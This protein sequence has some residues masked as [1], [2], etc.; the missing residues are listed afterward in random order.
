ML[1]SVAV[2]VVSPNAA[3]MDDA[4]P[5]PPTG[6]LGV[7]SDMSV[8]QRLDRR[9]GFTLI[10]LLVVIAIIAVLIALL[11][12][13]VQQ[14]REAARRVQ[15]KNNLKQIG[16]ALHNY[17]DANKVFPPGGCIQA[18]TTFAGNNGSWSIHGRILPYLEFTNAL[19]RVNLTVAWDNVINTSTGV[20]LLKV[21]T[22]VC[23]SELNSLFR[24]NG[25][26]PYT[27]PHTYGFNM[28]SWLIWDPATGQ[29]SDGI[30]W[31]NSSTNPA[32]IR[33]GLSSTLGAAEVKAFTSQSPR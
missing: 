26:A 30:F 33:D 5:L 28:G 13:A 24:T 18:G 1:R 15:C 29:G 27:Q 7:R 20:P 12:P 21:P 9:C 17:L 4:A 2:G 32:G 19:K 8:Q 6:D 16:L 31:M 25:G 23:P 22:Y 14:A 11:L 3:S 10:E